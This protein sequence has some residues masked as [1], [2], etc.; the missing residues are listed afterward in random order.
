MN[1]GGYIG[2]NS[3]WS[4]VVGPSARRPSPDEI[5]HMRTLVAEGMRAGAW[6]VSAGLDYKPAYYARTDEVV[7]VVSA[8]APWRT[9]FNN[10]E[11]L[12]PETRFSN[13][14]GV[15]ETLQIAQRSGLLGVVTHMKVT[16]K[17]QGSAATVLATLIDS[18]RRGHYVAADAYPYL[19]GMTALGALIIPAWAQDGGRPALL[20]RL[21]RP[22]LRGRIAMEAEQILVERFGGADVVY[23]PSLGKP[24]TAVMKEMSTGAGEAIVRLLEGSNPMAIL[25]FG[26]EEDLRLILQHPDTSIA[27]DCGS[28]TATATHPRNYGSFPRVLGRYVREQK[29]LTVQEAIRK[30]TALPAATIGMVDRGYLAPGMAADITVFDPEKVI[31]R[32]TYENPAALSE[33]VQHVFVNGAPALRDGKV[34][35]VQGGRVLAR[36]SGMPSRPMTKDVRRAVSMKGLAG[37]VV[38]NI[39]VSQS[40]GERHARGR[41]KLELPEQRKSLTISEFGILQVTAGW[42]S[43]TAQAKMEPEG[44]V[45]AVTIIVDEA[46][47]LSDG[48]GALIVEGEGAR[49]FRG[50]F[51]RGAVKA[52]I[53]DRR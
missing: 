30:M 40:P 32:A 7:Q 16:G 31:D 9:N 25:R 52:A 3:V 44:Q 20:E 19:A 1:V 27:C 53:G 48:A 46:D 29:I 12:T 21:A 47:P 15:A 34:T 37:S 36:G 24:L 2:F 6:G 51:P 18:G 4:N 33:G 38:V 13:A 45:R 17:E 49:A 22:E 43:L 10:H 11:R 14:V 26:I 8:A 50:T 5:E 42:A 41:L 39:D 28:T 35:G 23:L